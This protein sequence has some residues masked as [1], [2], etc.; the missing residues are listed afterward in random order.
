[1]GRRT[2]PIS[3]L[4]KF[5]RLSSFA[6]LAAIGVVMVLPAASGAKESAAGAA[7]SDYFHQGLGHH[8]STPA[9]AKDKPVHFLAP[10]GKGPGSEIRRFS[11]HPVAAS[12]S[13]EGLTAD[14]NN[15]YLGGPIQANPH[16]HLIYWGSNWNSYS[17]GPEIR[18]ALNQ[19]FSGVSGSGWQGILTQYF[20]APFEEEE[21]LISHSVTFNPA[22]DVY[23][24]TQVPAPSKVTYTKVTNEISAAQSAMGWPKG[25]WYGNFS[26]NDEL[27]V[28][29]TAPGTTYES[30]FL[31]QYCGFHSA[32]NYQAYA[33]L[34]STADEPFRGM[35][36][37][38]S[39]TQA[40]K[41]AS[42]EYAEA[43][44]D[45]IPQSAKFGEGKP[46]WET[47]IYAEGKVVGMTE[48]AD[49]CQMQPTGELANG[50]TVVSLRDN[51]HT[52]C[53]LSDP[54]PP[55]FDL[56]MDGVK[57]ELAGQAVLEA[58]IE[59][60]GHPTSYKFA[61]GKVTEFSGCE[62]PA[63]SPYPERI[64]GHFEHFE[65]AAYVSAGSG[66]GPVHVSL[67]ISGLEAHVQYCAKLMTQM[68]SDINGPDAVGVQSEHRAFTPVWPPQVTTGAASIEG[69]SGT[70]ATLHATVNPNAVKTTYQFEYGTTEYKVGDGPHGTKIPS[71]PGEAGSGTTD[72]QVSQ[73]L[74]SLAPATTYHFRVVASSAEGTSYGEDQSFTTWGKWSTQTTPNSPPAQT[75]SFFTDVSCPSV[76]LC[77]GVARD[78]WTSRAFVEKW[79]GS[80]WSILG[81]S[82]TQASANAIACTSATSC[83]L[84][85]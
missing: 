6:I 41:F 54:S 76:S 34:P 80:T 75:N 36:G 46:A 11:K 43:V 63:E 25:S 57:S 48:I 77:L 52:K 15:T 35:C 72:V 5:A 3:V 58:T 42:H 73:T 39:G 8:A 1:M 4:G 47:K 44:T 62:R 51:Y 79:N 69:A 45:P 81:N 56:S 13:E 53:M 55:Q 10:P 49:L 23:T 82:L 40:S 78:N 64:Y 29:L 22:T 83:L 18:S 37:E 21:R 24:D 16:V 17:H 2:S 33:F 31:G 67:P 50:A 14:T 60:A 27:Y 9:W 12:S 74:E 19:L 68:V 30:S 71:S 65:P 7:A 38:A 32:D 20:E 85:G 28:V 66:T 61:W 26:I 70:N 59:P 84:V